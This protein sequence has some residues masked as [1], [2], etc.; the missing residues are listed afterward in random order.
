MD[1][2][3]SIW[4]GVKQDGKAGGGDEA[5]EGR[6]TVRERITYQERQGRGTQRVLEADTESGWSPEY[7]GPE[8]ESG[9]VERRRE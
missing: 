8:L 5:R 1:K 3:R 9:S 4:Q 2:E 6:E 7:G